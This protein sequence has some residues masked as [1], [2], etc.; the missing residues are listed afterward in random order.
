MHDNTARWSAF[1]DTASKQ[2]NVPGGWEKLIPWSDFH[3]STEALLPG[4][5]ALDAIGW[6]TLRMLAT[7]MPPWKAG[8]PNA[9]AYIGCAALAKAA[10]YSDADMDRVALWY[11]ECGGQIVTYDKCRSSATFATSL[12]SSGNPSIDSLFSRLVDGDARSPRVFSTASLDAPALRR[13]GSIALNGTFATLAPVGWNASGR[14]LR[15]LTDPE[16]A[17]Y[18]YKLGV[19]T[20][21]D[22][23]SVQIGQRLTQLAFEFVVAHNRPELLVDF[24]IGPERFPLERTQLCG[25]A[26]ATFKLMRDVINYYIPSSLIDYLKTTKALRQVPSFQSVGYDVNALTGS[27]LDDAADRVMRA[28]IATLD[29]RNLPDAES[30]P[31]MLDWNYAR[32]LRDMLHDGPGLAGFRNWPAPQGLGQ[33]QDNGFLGFLATIATDVGFLGSIVATVATGG[34]AAPMIAIATNLCRTVLTAEQQMSTF[35][36][37]VGYHAGSWHGFAGLSPVLNTLQQIDL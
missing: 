1:T 19:R 15:V 16:C 36:A 26:N 12:S 9:L 25:G 6:S 13:D 27:A 4:G 10:G 8:D 14:P 11:V 29:D 24:V 18:L 5:E 17:A 33:S 31:S 32:I 21:A 35:A 28:I 7:G 22:L 3:Y 37:G 34:A 2:P 30:V 23:Y 20:A